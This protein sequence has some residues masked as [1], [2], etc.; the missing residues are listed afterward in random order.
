MR[1]R[2]AHLPQKCFPVSGSRKILTIPRFAPPWCGR[3]VRA[4]GV[5]DFVVLNTPTCSY[6]ATADTEVWEEFISPAEASH[7]NSESSAKLAPS[8]LS[9]CAHTQ[10]CPLKGEADSLGRG[11]LYD[12]TSHIH[13]AKDK[14]KE[15]SARTC[16]NQERINCWIYSQLI[17]ACQPS[18]SWR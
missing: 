11:S 5:E 2:C 3:A 4:L 15:Y 13:G 6:A 7:G 18:S 16:N 9:H 8:R 12:K 17:M 14:Q 1:E 10:K